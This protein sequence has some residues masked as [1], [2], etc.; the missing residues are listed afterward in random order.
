V[1]TV[2]YLVGRAEEICSL[3]ALLD[4]CGS[5]FAQA[6]AFTGEPGIGRRV[7]SET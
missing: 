6:V 7:F 1:V 3:E 2:D 5:G 4:E